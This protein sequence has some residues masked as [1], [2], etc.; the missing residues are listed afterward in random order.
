MA[1]SKRYLQH[2][3]DMLQTHYET[4]QEYDTTI[5]LA[6]LKYSWHYLKSRWPIEKQGFDTYTSSIISNL[7]DIALTC[8]EIL[9]RVTG[10]SMESIIA[11]AIELHEQKNAGYS[12][13]ETDAWANFRVCTQFGIPATD[14]C[15]VRLCDKYSRFF[16]VYT[17]PA[18]DKV[19]ESATDTLKDMA[20]YSVILVTLL[21]EKD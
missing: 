17:N 2:L 14:G 16:S 19:G 4:I 7:K 3:D 15:L 11:D 1:V 18:N 8:Y 9:S 20:A 13:S 10:Q 6:E 12:P 21:E 5:L